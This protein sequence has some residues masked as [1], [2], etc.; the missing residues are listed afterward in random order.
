MMFGQIYCLTFPDGKEYIG[1]TTDSLSVRIASHRYKA[2]QGGTSKVL[3]AI[4]KHKGR[5]QTMSL[6]ECDN[7][8]EL[9]TAERLFIQERNTMHPHGHNSYSGGR[10][11]FDVDLETRAKIS[12]K[13]SGE[14]NHSFGKP[15]IMLGKKH[16]QKTRALISAKNRGQ[17]RTP[18]QCANISKALCGVPKPNARG[19]P[20]SPTHRANMSAAMRGLKRTISTCPHCGK[21]GGGGNMRRYHFDNCKHMRNIS[22]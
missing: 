9:D 19:V 6:Y 17:K 18:E 11:G 21:T 7:Q 16:T 1:Q 14:R 22:C 8:Y 3:A 5:F 15:G 20:K 2:K 13:M 4:R 12:E 10:K